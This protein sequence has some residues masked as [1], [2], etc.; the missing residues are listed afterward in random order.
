M[1]GEDNVNLWSF[2][3]MKIRILFVLAMM[4]ASAAEAQQFVLPDSLGWNVVPEGK[5][6]SLQLT[7]TDALKPKFSMDGANGY[8]F[9]LD[10]VGHLVWTPS[11]ETAD[12]IERKKEVSVILQ[13]DW[14]DGRKIRLPITFVVTHV[15][16]PPEIEELPIFYVRQATA[17]RYQVPAEY[18]RDPDGDPV[19]FKSIPSQMPEGLALTSQGQWTWTPSRNQFNSLKN[20]PLLVDFLVQD[21]PDKAET[22]GR[23][24]IAQT[25]LDLPPE[26]LL[27]PSD[28]LLTVKEDARI[29]FKIYV[30]DPNGDDNISHV[31]FV[32]SDIRIPREALKSNTTLQYE[33]TW[34]PGYAFVEEVEKQREAELLFFAIDKSNNRTQRRVKI[35]VLDAENMEEKDRLLYQKYRSAL[36]QA[37]SLIDELDENHEKLNRMY[38]QAKKGK[39]NRAIVNASLGATTG[40]SPLLLEN[41]EGK[42]VSGV[43]GTAVLTLGTLE[44]TEVV[45]KSRSDIVEKQKINVELRNQLQVEG[46]NF[47]RKYALKSSR[48]GKDFEIDR[49]KLQPVLNNQK[50]VFLELDAAKPLTRRYDSK[51]IKKTFPDFSEE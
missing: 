29:N 14:R 16:R 4:G 49:D 32:G 39:K 31:E 12:R 28:T 36:V 44:A 45:G 34:T 48:R 18:V 42:I 21:Q 40:L 33:F 10:T 38:K 51:D 3:P 19:V 27:V 25:Q 46:D 41:E 20:N 47:A 5:T 1:W 23:L 35:V 50:L 24:K 8:G 30:S 9:L 7:T 13:A 37:K 43:G 26:L 2:F 11:Y 22:K 15:N 6:L 17:N